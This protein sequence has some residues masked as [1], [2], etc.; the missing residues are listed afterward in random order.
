MAIKALDV[1]YSDFISVLLTVVTVVL[2]AVGIMIG[3][4]AAYTVT[5]IKDDAREAVDKAVETRLAG[6]K[7]DVA[8]IA[9]QMGNRGPTVEELEEGFDPEEMEE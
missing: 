3:V 6:L 4:V 1:A 5:T 2:G 8:K 9:F 7:K